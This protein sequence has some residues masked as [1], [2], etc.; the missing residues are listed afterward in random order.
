MSF[1]SRLRRPEE[2]PVRPVPS[3]LQVE[4]VECGAASLAMILAYHGRWVPLEELRAACGVSR[5]GTKASNLLR[6]A[7]GFGLNAKGFRKELDPLAEMAMPVILFWGFNHFVVLEGF[8]GGQALINDP[9]SGRRTVDPDQ[10]EAAFT[11]V[12]LAFEPAEGFERGGAPAQTWTL[13]W[14]RLRGSRDGLIHVGLAT[15]ALLIPG[16]ALPVFAR[17]FIDDILIGRQTD[18]LVPMLVLMAGVILLRSGLTWV[19]QSM[20]A[21]LETKLA[22]VPSSQLLWRMLGLPMGFFDQRQSG[23]LISRVDASDRIA[24]ELSGGLA[25]NVA[26]LLLVLFYGLVMLTFAPLLA[27]GV[28]ALSATNIAAVR[29]SRKGL[30]PMTRLAGAQLGNLIAATVG[31]IQAI[32]TIKASSLEGQAHRRWVGRQAALLDLRRKIGERAMLIGLVPLVTTT[33]S[34]VMVLGGGSL[35]VMQG[36]LTV[37][38]L[39]AFVALAEQFGQPLA[40]L[41]AYGATIQ[42]IRADLMRVDDVMRAKPLAPPPPGEPLRSAALDVRELSFGYNPLEKPII[43][44]LSFSI[45]PGA[46]IALVGGSGSGKSTI[47]RLIVGL[48][49]RWGGDV[50]VDGREVDGIAPGDRAGI[51]AYVDQDVFL[52]EGTV[53]DNLSL[54]DSSIEDREL[55][56]ALA[57]AALLDDISDRQGGLDAVVDEGGSNF[58]G[59]QRQRLEIAR[60]LVGRPQLLVLDE[61]TAALDPT[62]EKLIDENLRRRGCA[63]LIIAHRLSTIRDADE[64]IVLERGRIVER[65]Q[66]AELVERGGEYAQLVR[67]G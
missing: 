64:I 62:T 24:A 11:G 3:I 65:G 1:L 57:D 30:E 43:D 12:V 41:V 44:A 56:A 35:M 25:S 26:S 23:E 8:R 19:Q 54:W 61:A 40:S 16:L 22:V 18:W 14:D 9:A 33:L 7:R 63:C 39:V 52:F 27:L 5:D 37:G 36:E 53:R 60:A 15:L 6:A 47:G 21:K 42:T 29:W 4:A 67:A 34:R 38:M 58:S 32:E 48:A 20:L 31:P 28:M 55:T 66:H 13:L 2:R 59:G 17:V 45:A 51:I 46:R 49:Q 10:F 50:L